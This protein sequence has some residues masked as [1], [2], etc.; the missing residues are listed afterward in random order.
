[1][2]KQKQ[3]A[4]SPMTLGNIVTTRGQHL[5]CLAAGVLLLAACD[6]FLSTSTFHVLLGLMKT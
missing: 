5:V 1:M 6:D 2:A 4:G 3:P